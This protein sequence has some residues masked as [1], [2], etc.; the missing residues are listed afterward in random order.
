VRSS[1]LSLFVLAGVALGCSP[2]DEP[3]PPRNGVN[4]V[5]KACEIRATW[6][7]STDAK[8]VNCLVAAPSPACECEAF[9]DFASLCLEQDTAR[10][11]EP[12]CTVALDDCTKACVPTDCNCVNGCY[13]QA[14]TCKR[15]SAAKDGCIADVCTPY[16]Q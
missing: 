7:K 6:T 1:V 5:Q 8:C 9:K 2:K 10:R 14:E 12:S 11:A 15:L 13:A 4:D 3:P 16:C